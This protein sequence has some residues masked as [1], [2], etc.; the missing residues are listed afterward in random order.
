[1]ATA[2]SDRDRRLAHKPKGIT[3]GNLR[4][5]KVQKMW[6]HHVQ[7]ILEIWRMDA[8]YPYPTWEL[9]RETA[10]LHVWTMFDLLEDLAKDGKLP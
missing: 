2:V 5:I 4:Y 7:D 10:Y 6:A 8:L 3:V 9:P 1:M